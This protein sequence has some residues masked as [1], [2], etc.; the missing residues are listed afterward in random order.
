VF[1]DS[2]QGLNEMLQQGYVVAATDYPGLGTSG[3]HPYLVGLSEGRA[4]L[5][6]VRAARSMA[7]SDSAF[8]VWGHS[9]GG[10]AALYAGILAANYAPELKLSEWLPRRPPLTWAHCLPT[11]AVPRV[12]R[13][14]P[15]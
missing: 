15:R 8:A 7:G 2:I 3:P 9:Q 11:A 6:S 1:F 13:T 14:S 5:D 10:H 4:A 12:A